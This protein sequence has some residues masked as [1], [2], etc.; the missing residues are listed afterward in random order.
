MG[1]WCTLLIITGSIYSFQPFSCISMYGEEVV[2]FMNHNRLC[3]C[4]STLLL[5]QYV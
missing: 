4:F 2:Y 3:L 1:R 5:P